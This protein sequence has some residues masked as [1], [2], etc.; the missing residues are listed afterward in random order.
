MPWCPT[1]RTS[2]LPFWAFPDPPAASRRPGTTRSVALCV[3]TARDVDRLPP[4]GH[5]ASATPAPAGHRRASMRLPAPRLRPRSPARPYAAAGPAPAASPEPTHGMRS[6]EPSC[7]RGMPSRT[8]HA[9]GRPPPPGMTALRT[10]AYC[11]PLT[12]CTDRSR[13]PPAGRPGRSRCRTA[14]SRCRRN[15]RPSTS[16]PWPLRSAPPG[17]CGSG[18]DPYRP[19]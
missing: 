18:T 13:S 14:S 17:C 3:N 5:H 12:G 16:R 10:T 19:G 1:R 2:P 8:A 11:L 7:R 6:R 9:G 15:R 4:T